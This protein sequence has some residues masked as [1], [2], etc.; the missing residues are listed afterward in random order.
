MEVSLN[1]REM[2]NDE[3]RGV[4]QISLIIPITERHDDMF[5]IYQEYKSALRGLNIPFEMIAV[6]DGAFDRAYQQL[7]ELKSRGEKITI[8]KHARTFG[9]STAIMAGFRISTGDVILLAPPYHQVEMSDLPKVMESFDGSDMVVVRRWPRTDSRWNQ[10]QT[11]LFHYLVRSMAGS[12]ASDIGCGVRMFRREVL[13]EI[14]LYG[15]LHRF[16]PV[17]AF[18]QGFKIREVDAR[19]SPKEKRLRTYPLGTYLR[20]MIDLLTVFFLIK[21]TKKPL[22][23]FG[24]TGTAVLVTGLAITGYLVV[25]RLF[26]RVGLSDRPLFLVGILL[27]VLGLQIFAIGLIGELIIFIHARD[28]KEYQIEQIIN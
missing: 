4:M 15:D 21:F 2:A 7:K 27:V 1:G 28:V 18:R 8:I 10:F 26:F 5:E 20:R 9:E 14:P 3:E 24:L 13:D 19:Q 22:R 25:G 11:N 17:L 16:L 12:V 6:V 23:F